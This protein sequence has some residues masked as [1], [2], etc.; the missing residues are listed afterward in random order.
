MT[1]DKEMKTIF[2]AIAL[3][4]VFTPISRATQ[5]ESDVLVIRGKRIYTHDTP[6]LNKAFP[7][8]DIPKFEMI[9]TANYKGYS[10]TW[11]VI[12]G[13]L[14][15]IGLEALVGGKMLWDEHVLKGQKFPLKVENWSGAVTQSSPVS[16][17]DPNTGKSER[18]D[19]VTTIVF[20]KSKVTK[21][22]FD[23]KVPRQDNAEEE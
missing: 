14:Y 16:S 10:P 4:L 18:Y 19:E 15:L 7:K 17:Y 3:L 9:S 22:D 20:V 1:F 23:Q 11:A 8:L 6:I 5:Q 21:V 2:S 13:Q 12:E